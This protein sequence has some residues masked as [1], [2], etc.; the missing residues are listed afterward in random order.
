MWLPNTEIFCLNYD[1]FKLTTTIKEQWDV[2]DTASD[3]KSVKFPIG[4]APTI[5]ITINA[6]ISYAED[7]TH[8]EQEKGRGWLRT[9][10]HG[11]ID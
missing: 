11:D 3:A 2:V 10:T 6:F 1:L 4:H 8:G 5:D 7:S 9:S